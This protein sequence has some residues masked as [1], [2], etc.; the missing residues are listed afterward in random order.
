MV[1]ALTFAISA[2]FPRLSMAGST[3]VWILLFWF[4]SGPFLWV[5]AVIAASLM[6]AGLHG[7]S[8][9]LAFIAAG[10]AIIM[11]AY[12]VSSSSIRSMRR[13]DLT[14]ATTKRNS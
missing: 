10:W 12:V 2:M 11:L 8:L 1:N 6:S 9:W 3:W 13:R 7:V 5:Y 14:F 4:G